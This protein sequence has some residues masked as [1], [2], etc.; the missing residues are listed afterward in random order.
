MFSVIPAVFAIGKA[1]MLFLYPL[2]R[3]KVME[4]EQALARR[5]TLDVASQ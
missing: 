3:W 1:I 2:N 5:K 4:N